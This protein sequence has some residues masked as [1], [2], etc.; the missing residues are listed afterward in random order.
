MSRDPDGEAV[1]PEGLKQLKAHEGFRADVYRDSE[2]L[3]TIGYGHCLDRKGVSQRVADL[4]LEDDVTDAELIC[5]VRFPFWKDM[6]P[7]RQDAFV[8]LVFNLGGR[9]LAGFT[10]FIQACEEG[11]WEQARLHLLDSKY[12]TQVGQRAIELAEQIRS[13][14]FPAVR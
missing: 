6:N 2:G 3:L 7:A 10:K 13:G 14:E 11:A 5:R 12:A 1:T 9:G 8:N 4:M